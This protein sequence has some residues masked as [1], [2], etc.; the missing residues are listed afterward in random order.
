MNLGKHAIDVHAKHE[1]FVDH[2]SL[3]S[4]Y[5]NHCEAILRRVIADIAKMMKIH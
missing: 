1:K 4:K 2:G 3:V 5:L